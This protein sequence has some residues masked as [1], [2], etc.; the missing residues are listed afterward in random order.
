MANKKGSLGG[1]DSAG[2]N[3]WDIDSNGNIVPGTDD[4]KSIGSAS[5]ALT[6]AYIKKTFHLG[7]LEITVSGSNLYFNGAQVTTS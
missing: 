5:K 3:D 7:G 4:V 6:D 1:K 2:Q